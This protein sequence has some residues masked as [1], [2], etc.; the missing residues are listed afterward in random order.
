MGPAGMKPAAAAGVVCAETTFGELA[1]GQLFVI[2]KTVA[3]VLADWGR[4]TWAPVYLKCRGESGGM[5][6]NTRVVVVR[7]V[8]RAHARSREET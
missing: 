5:A 3:D 8:Q 6:A 7:V 1:P 2:G 4:H